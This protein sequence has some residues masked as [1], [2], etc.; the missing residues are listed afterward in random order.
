M[1]TIQQ[2]QDYFT[3]DRFAIDGVGIVIDEVTRGHAICSFP[4]QPRHLNAHDMVMGGAIFTLADFAFGIAANDGIAPVVTLNATISYL[5]AAKGTRLIAE[6]TTIKAG[7]STCV[8]DIKV[9]DELGTLVA[10]STMTGF[11]KG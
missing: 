1:D 11:R 9:R 3:K 5:S 2:A 6:S 4:I 7:R 8:V 10:V